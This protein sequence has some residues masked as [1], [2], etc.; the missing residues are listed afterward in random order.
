MALQI[1]ECLSYNGAQ[2]LLSPTGTTTSI[3]P[4]SSYDPS[5]QKYVIFEKLRNDRKMKNFICLISASLFKGIQKVL[6]TET[7]YK[8]LVL[9][10]Y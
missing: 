8:Y 6:Q 7:A 10:A 3:F 5:H 9:I 4:S 1:D 2:L